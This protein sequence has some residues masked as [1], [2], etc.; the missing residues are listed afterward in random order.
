M[1]LLA[2]PEAPGL[3]AALER[4]AGA[5]DVGAR[6]DRRARR[7][8]AQ[9]RARPRAATADRRRAS[10]SAAGFTLADD[11]L[12][13]LVAHGDEIALAEL[14]GRRLA[15]LDGETPASRARLVRH[16]ARVARP[17][18]RGR[19]GWPP[20]STCT[21]RRSAT[22]SPVCASC[23]GVG[24]RRSGGAVRARARAAQ[25]RFVDREPGNCSTS[26]R[27]REPMNETATAS[28]DIMAADNADQREQVIELLTKA[29]LD[30]DRDG[31]ELH[32]Q[33]GQPRRRPR[34]GDQGVA[35]AGH[36]GGAR[37]RAAVRRADQGALRGRP[38]LAGLQRRAELPAAARRAGRHRPR[39]QGRDRGRGRA[40]SSTTAGSSRRPTAS[41]R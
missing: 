11:H 33:L 22:G 7:G 40:R 20:S 4:A 25:P 13:A 16:P 5:A 34:A 12:A 37:P 24:P 30:G 26:D 14:A 15:P 19:R 18:G 21:R 36:P 6:A 10:S 2:D 23:F 9:R 38:R 29:L 3:R 31:D 1:A 32:R 8:A 28:G 27:K 35:R 41:T 17:P 39:D